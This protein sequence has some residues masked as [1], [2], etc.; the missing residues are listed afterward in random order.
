MDPPRDKAGF[1]I[2]ML[3]NLEF[4]QENDN[5]TVKSNSFYFHTERVQ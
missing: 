4:Q 2:K 5:P 1:N 3:K